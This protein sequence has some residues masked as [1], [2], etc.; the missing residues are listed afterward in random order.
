MSFTFCQVS[1]VLCI[2]QCNDG[3]LSLKK[4]CVCVYISPCCKDQEE[5]LF[6]IYKIY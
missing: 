3:L 5:V 1:D 4:Y 2:T 6:N